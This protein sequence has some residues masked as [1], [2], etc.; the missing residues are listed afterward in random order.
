MSDREKKVE[1]RER[2]GQVEVRRR[3]GEGGQTISSEPANGPSS[4]TYDLARTQLLKFPEPPQIVPQA[5]TNQNLGVFFPF[6]LQHH[7]IC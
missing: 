3:E 2:K 6:T 1:R 7:C 4:L 5:G